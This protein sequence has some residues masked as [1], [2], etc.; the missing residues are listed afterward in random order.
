[1]TAK[2]DQGHKQHKAAQ[3]KVGSSPSL[4][5]MVMMACILFKDQA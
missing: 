5:N 2:S 3:T 4:M 1:M